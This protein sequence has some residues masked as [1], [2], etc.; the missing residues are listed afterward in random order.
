MYIGTYCNRIYDKDK[1]LN[2]IGAYMHIKAWYA[3]YLHTINE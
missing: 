3:S 1:H 2:N